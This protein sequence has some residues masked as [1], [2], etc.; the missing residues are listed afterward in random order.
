M[1]R[2]LP[3]RKNDVVSYNDGEL[4]HPFS[5]FTLEVRGVLPFTQKGLNKSPMDTRTLE[6]V[7]HAEHN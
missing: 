1:N 6:M 3:I 2:L 7:R 4:Q 5:S